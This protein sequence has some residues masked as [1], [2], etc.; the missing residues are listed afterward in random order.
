ME[1]K[2]RPLGFA[3]ASQAKSSPLLLVGQLPRG[4]LDKV[5]LAIS[6][7]V[8]ALLVFPE[9]V[10][11]VSEALHRLKE[12]RPS[13]GV[14]LSE[15]VPE[16][17]GK[18]IELGCEFIVFGPETS[19]GLLGEEKFGRVLLVEPS[20][21]DGL[22]QATGKL[23][24]DAVLLSEEVKPPLTIG[25]LMNYQRL[26][27][28]IGKPSLFSLTGEAGARELEALCGV[29]FRAIVVHLGQQSAKKLASL[30]K[31]VGSL[32]IPKRK[33]GKAGALLPAVEL[34][35]ELIEEEI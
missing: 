19:A 15:K 30:R 3:P 33:A 29:G 12:L 23:P 28:L 5:D 7:Q 8:D 9:D 17:L 4:Q 18:L 34:P 6:Q 1:G 13:W 16:N 25:Q 20:L 31:T 14:W 21:A 24:I 2:T 11:A 32:K 27:A 35:E 10:Q 22:A 26:L